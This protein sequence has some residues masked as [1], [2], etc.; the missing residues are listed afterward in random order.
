MTRFLNTLLL[1]T[2]LVIPV[3]VT[4]TLLR[5]QEHKDERV[6]H[7]KQRNEDHH[8]DD[9]EDKAYHMWLKETHHKEGEFAKLKEKDQQAYWNWRHDHSD[10]LLKIDIH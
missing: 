4:P 7:D 9:H 2:A 5:A 1:S 6:Y 3:T 10:A 8:W